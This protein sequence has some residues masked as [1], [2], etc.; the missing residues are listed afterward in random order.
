MI[1]FRFA[2][3]LRSGMDSLK[4]SKLRSF[5]TMFGVIIGVAAVI[6]IVAIGN[7]IKQQIGSQI[8]QYGSNIIT[9]R[10]SELS[11]GSG[12][13]VNN[14][15]ALSGLSV[16]G[17]LTGSDYSTVSKAS[18][19]N[20]SAPLSLVSGQVSGDN[21]VYKNGFVIGTTPDLSNLLNQSLA[22]GNFIGNQDAGTSVA[23]L[24]PKAALS[25]FNEDVPLGRSF[26]FREHNFLVEGI[27]N[28]FNS[29]PL[30]QQADFNN[31]VFIPY[32]VGQSLTNNTSP[33]Y[34]ILARAAVQSE[35]NQVAH[36]IKS[37]LNSTHGGQSGFTILTGSQN[38]AVNNSIL[39]LLT[40]LIAGVAGISL[41]VAGIGIMNV[42][43]VSV[44]E[45]VREIGIRKAV[46]A[47][48]RQILSQFMLESALISF[49][50]GVIGIAL[51]FFIDF[52]IRISTDFRP[53]IT[54]QIVVIASG[55][56]LFF[57]IVFGS[58]PA[59]KA[60]AKDPIEALRAE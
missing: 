35:T 19:V 49:I 52:A 20:S 46:G 29:S 8:H 40:K 12:S 28:D 44:S 9:V 58:I 43:L 57:G 36:N 47:T 59:I 4:H 13:S 39:G 55:V 45:R 50:G 34:E 31:A 16:S 24:G 6:T 3:Q 30:S 37:A 33:V 32:D 23:V 27:F 60:A 5:W 38:L 1:G 56:S 42:M 53:D 25:L 14:V 2:A 15:S 21:G 26:K 11:F 22:Y 10:T 17:P 41:L 51:A 7:G 54:W 18:G 48:N